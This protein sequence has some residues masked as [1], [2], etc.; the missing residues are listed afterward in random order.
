MG[1][2][3]SSSQPKSTAAPL[4]PEPGVTDFASA[5]PAPSAPPPLPAEEESVLA[6]A[7]AALARAAPTPP[8]LP[9]AAL[10]LRTLQSRTPPAPPYGAREGGG[11]GEE[12]RTVA[13][14][15]EGTIWGGGHG[16]TGG[17]IRGSRGRW[18]SLRGVEE[19]EEVGCVA[20]RFWFFF[21]WGR[22][23]PPARG[24]KRAR[25]IRV[26]TREPRGYVRSTNST[27]LCILL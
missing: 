5:A 20:S 13:A 19:S 16:G 24:P 4:L 27:L 1:R 25:R 26:G 6:L 8:P 18:G 12:A 3:R 7:A 21:D 14:A 23:S 15:G 2:P 22:T 9:P 17:A 11:R 10:P